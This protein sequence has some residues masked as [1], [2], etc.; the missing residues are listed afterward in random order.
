MDGLLEDLPLAALKGASGDHYKSPPPA[1]H[2]AILPHNLSTF[3][4]LSS[5]MAARI[6]CLGPSVLIPSSFR[7]P[8]V[9]VRNA[10]MSTCRSRGTFRKVESIKHTWVWGF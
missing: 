6:C 4:V 1:N 7:S 9:R 3:P 5:E 10:S 8:S 2:D